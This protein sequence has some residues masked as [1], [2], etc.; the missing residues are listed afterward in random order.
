MQPS[1]IID[2][3]FFK[4]KKDSGTA[5]TILKQH[6]EVKQA[7]VSREVQRPTMSR[8]HILT[9]LYDSCPKAAIF[10]T[11]SGFREQD[12]TIIQ[13][14]NDCDPDL[15]LPLCELYDPKHCSLGESDLMDLVSHTFSSLNVSPSAANFLELS[16]RK[17]ASSTTWFR[18]RKGLITASHFSAVLH[19]TWGC[20][21]KSTVS[22]IMQF[23]PVNPSVPALKWGREHEEIARD[24][25]FAWADENH[26]SLTI[27]DSGLVINPAFPYLGAMPDGVITCDCCGVGLVEIKCPYKYKDVHPTALVAL[28]D[29]GYCLKESSGVV[30]LSQNHTYYHQIQAQMSIC[31]IDYCDF[32]CWTTT[33]FFAKELQDS[34]IICHLIV[35]T[36]RNSLSCT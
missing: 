34:R 15:P 17:Q 28:S 16:T 20:Y 10:T 14:N 13:H 22:A 8:Q 35:N 30:T 25:Y 21:P 2:L 5:E 33:T 7:R 11:L 29:P 6:E 1:P 4:P 18:Y 3:L 26:D 31:D 36:W 32:I 24:E 23:N 27:R 12:Q 9:H 19:H